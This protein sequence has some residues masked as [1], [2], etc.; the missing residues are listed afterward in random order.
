[1]SPNPMSATSRLAMQAEQRHRRAR[2]WHWVLGGL[3]VALVVMIGVQSYSSQ[4]ELGGSGDPNATSSIDTGPWRDPGALP[5]WDTASPGIPAEVT[6]RSLASV[7]KVLGPHGSGTGWIARSG[8]VITNNHVVQLG[9]TPLSFQINGGP[10]VPC[11]VIGRTQSL[12]IAALSCPTGDRPAIPIGVAD[13]DQGVAVLTIGYP[14][15][16]GP[17]ITTGGV[18]NT[19]EVIND[20]AAIDTSAT[21][22][23]GS[24]GSPIIDGNGHVVAMATWG[25]GGGRL[26]GVRLGEVRHYLDHPDEFTTLHGGENLRRLE[27][28]FGIGLIGFA[29]GAF[30]K[31]R[32]GYGG[33]WRRAVS[34]AIGGV[35]VG[36]IVAQAIVLASDPSR[37]LG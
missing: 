28:A 2:Q 36:L 35:L 29:L 7:G 25:S 30:T 17:A 24:S 6:R 32:S 20:I 34:L 8:I 27:W 5:G 31:Y 19:A 23:P 13:V 26:S 37:I 12:E 11:E 21:G 22:A 1:M 4:S 16:V 18:T 15:G 10:S 14:L 3:A 9:G 33:V